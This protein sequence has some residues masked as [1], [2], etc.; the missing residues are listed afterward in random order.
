[1]ICTTERTLMN[2]ILDLLLQNLPIKKKNN[3]GM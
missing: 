1:M 3:D 2:K